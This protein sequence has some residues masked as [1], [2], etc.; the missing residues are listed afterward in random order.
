MRRHITTALLCDFGYSPQKF[1]KRL[2]K[3]FGGRSFDELSEVEQNHYIRLKQQ[4]Q[5]FDEWF[6]ADERKAIINYMRETSRCMRA[7][8]SIYPQYKSELTTRRI[9]QEEAIGYCETLKEEL[10]YTIETLPVDVNKYTVIAEMIDKEIEYIKEWRKSDN[11]R[12]KKA[13]ADTEAK[14]EADKERARKTQEKER[15][16]GKQNGGKPPFDV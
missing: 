5:A 1:E 8:N 14:F 7:A 6:I 10:Q 2:E 13:V 3:R 16:P 4:E 15:K 12:F 11:G 9:H